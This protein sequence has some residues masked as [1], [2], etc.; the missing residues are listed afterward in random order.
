MKK[1]RG[2]NAKKTKRII[3]VVLIAAIVAAVAAAVVAVMLIF[4]PTQPKDPAYRYN[5]E[6][7][8]GATEHKNAAE[9]KV[10]FDVDFDSGAENVPEGAVDTVKEYFTR[11]YSSLGSYTACDISDLYSFDTD[12]ELG[13]AETMRDYQI[14]I[15]E[16][17]HID[18]SFD[19]CRVG[20]RFRKC[21]AT[22]KGVGVSLYENNS[23]D[24][25]FLDGVTSYTS[26]V[27][28]D[29]VLEETE[30]GWFIV[31]HSEITGVY[32]L[33]TQGF[34][35]LCDENNLT[36]SAL[37][38][39]QIH[40]YFAELNE[41]LI[42]ETDS[43]LADLGRNRDKFN[44]R[45]SR[46]EV[47]GKADHPYDADAAVAYSYEWAG[48]TEMLRNPNFTA[49]DEYGG[50]CN[51][52][53][54]QCLLAGGIPM[55]VYGAIAEQWK[56]YGDSIVTASSALGR[57]MSW[58]GVEDFWRYCRANT[59]YGLVCD[60]T[61]NVYCAREG[62]IVQY[63][64]GERGVHSVIIS[65]VIRD[66]AGNVVELLVNSNTTDKVDSPMSIY[67]YTD[68]RLIRIIGWNG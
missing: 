11:Y 4:F 56:Y 5:S 1:R 57:S 14:R 26:G 67:G 35:D 45:P 68:F 16:N 49:Y 10:D 28:H 24:Y 36:L 50:N 58:T 59:G 63:I 18:L 44:A 64:S 52:F 47:D 40:D 65:K 38:A 21:E 53:T 41:Q 9:V 39:T 34:D 54:S 66:E 30:G 13:V 27:E 60:C 7:K 55:D 20:L 51:N 25:A 23:M 61:D 19:A 22:D 8:Y 37:T 48:K 2:K 46:F 33:I 32:S 62:D 3:L 42:E 43:G 12:Y 17:M 15:R 31:S 29:F 6:N